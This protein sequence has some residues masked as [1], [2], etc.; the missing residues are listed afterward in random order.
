LN[1]NAT[2]NNPQVI[3]M[4][5]RQVNGVKLSEYQPQHKY[6]LKELQLIH[7]AG[8][9]SDRHLVRGR[10]VYESRNP[11]RDKWSFKPS[12]LAFVMDT[13]A[14]GSIVSC[15]VDQRSEVPITIVKGP[16]GRDVYRYPAGGWGTWHGQSVTSSCPQGYRV[17][18]CLAGAKGP[19][20][21]LSDCEPTLTTFNGMYLGNSTGSAME[22][23]IKN[24]SNTTCRVAFNGMFADST[25][26]FYLRWHDTPFCV[27]AECVAVTP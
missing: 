26:V 20:N 6:R 14:V 24:T 9:F 23:T 10:A 2:S 7:L 19:G 12:D 16:V 5:D 21:P 17:M 22:M 13:N 27:V 25:N 15:A 11:S 4:E 18:R 8:P 3:D 1:Q